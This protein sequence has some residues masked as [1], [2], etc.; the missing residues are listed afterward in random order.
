MT[1]PLR[2]LKPRPVRHGTVWEEDP[3]SVTHHRGQ[4]TLSRDGVPV[5][6][7]QYSLEA[8]SADKFGTTTIVGSI[9]TKPDLVP[10]GEQAEFVLI[11]A[12]R[13]TL[14]CQLQPMPTP[15]TYEVIALG[16]IEAPRP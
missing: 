7:A 8:W 12:T 13:A 1:W 16:G 15:E 2:Q 14:R 10:E 6:L 3:V 4:G 9:E 5:A 11:L